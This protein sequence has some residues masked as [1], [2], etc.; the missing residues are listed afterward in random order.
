M[1]LRPMSV[2]VVCCLGVKSVVRDVLAT[3]DAAS[4]PL[5]D[6]NSTTHRLPRTKHRT[7]ASSSLVLMCLSSGR[8]FYLSSWRRVCFSA[9]VRVA[10]RVRVLHCCQSL[11]F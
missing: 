5:C 9:V 4:P 10:R 8:V 2:L 7:A 3:N 6:Q 1:M 11:S